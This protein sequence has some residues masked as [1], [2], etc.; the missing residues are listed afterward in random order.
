MRVPLAVVRGSVVRCPAGTRGGIDASVERRGGVFEHVAASI[1]ALRRGRGRNEQDGTEGEDPRRLVRGAPRG[2]GRIRGR[3][4]AETRPVS[5]LVLRVNG[6]PRTL[7]AGATVADLVRDLG[8][9]PEVVAVEVNERLVPRAR[10]TE[11]RLED[12]DRVEVVT[13]VGGG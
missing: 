11:T 3:V 10:R 6:A 4:N 1:R 8:L 12:G 7:A 5:D 13:L 2:Y 9:V